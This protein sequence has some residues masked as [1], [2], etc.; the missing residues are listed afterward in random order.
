MIPLF[1]PLSES[2]NAGDD[3]CL[4]PSSSLTN[5]TVDTSMGGG[6][7]FCDAN[8][9][10]ALNSGNMNEET[11]R[12]ISR[13]RKMLGE[14]IKIVKDSIPSL[15]TLVRRVSHGYDSENGTYEAFCDGRNI[16]VNL[17]SYLHKVHPNHSPR[18]LIH[19]LVI[20]VTHEIAHF[21]EPRA[22]H[23]PLWRDTHMSMLIQVMS[24][25]EMEK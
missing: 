8:T 24:R 20:T 3:T 15:E 16:I 25:L 5:V 17:F 10:D 23:G 6:K 7:M 1:P 21:L 2:D 19:D 18:D 4:R 13:I 22:G 14:A 11:K 9:V 12:K